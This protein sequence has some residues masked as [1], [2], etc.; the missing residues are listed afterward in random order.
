M[1]ETYVHASTLLHH[2]ATRL[3]HVTTLLHHAST[4]LHHDATRLRR[5]ATLLHRAATLLRHA[6]T[7]HPPS[8]QQ[9]RATR[10]AGIRAGSGLAWPQA[11]FA[12]AGAAACSPRHGKSTGWVRQEWTEGGSGGSPRVSARA[13]SRLD[14]AGEKSGVGRTIVLGHRSRRRGI[15]M[16]FRDLCMIVV[17]VALVA[18]FGT[19]VNAWHPALAPAWRTFLIAAGVVLIALLAVPTIR[20]RFG[21]GSQTGR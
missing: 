1:A 3:R 19:S 16:S 11:A 6:A 10:L 4:L 13:S 14:I 15:L 17:G 20:N 18:G 8:R 9:S 12:P 21:R 5:A 7:L 2:D